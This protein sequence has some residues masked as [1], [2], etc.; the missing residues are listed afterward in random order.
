MHSDEL[1]MFAVLLNRLACYIWAATDPEGKD[2]SAQA[3]AL[4]N[5]VVREKEFLTSQVVWKTSY[6]NWEMWNERSDANR[7]RFITSTWLT[8][9]DQPAHPEDK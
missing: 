5:L 3:L 6:E 8:A 1:T 2:S 4:K 9:P 7:Y